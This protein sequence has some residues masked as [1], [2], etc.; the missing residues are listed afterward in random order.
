MGKTISSCASAFVLRGRPMKN[1]KLHAQV[2]RK[3]S[4]YRY[5]SE[6][7]KLLRAHTIQCAAIKKDSST[8][9]L[10]SSK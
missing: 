4:K 10:M 9:S 1:D 2:Q 5:R 8:E 6:T 7:E 3:Q